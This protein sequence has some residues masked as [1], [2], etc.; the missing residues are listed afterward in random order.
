MRMRLARYASLAW[1]SLL[2]GPSLAGTARA[3]AAQT[4][5]YPAA[6]RGDVVDDYHGTQGPDPYRWLEDPDAPET[7]AW[8]E[9]ENPLS[10]AYLA[11]LPAPPR[12]RDRLPALW[13]YPKD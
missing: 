4:L 5:P 10:A 8:S 9:A 12:I 11:A 3:A 2:I 6:H 13:P 1:S 7:R